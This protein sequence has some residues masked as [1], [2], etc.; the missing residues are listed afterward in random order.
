MNLRETDVGVNLP[1]LGAKPLKVLFPFIRTTW[2]LAKAA[3]EYSPA[4]LLKLLSPEFRTREALPDVVGKA[5]TGVTFLTAGAYL[6][7][8]GRL[9]GSAPRD[10]RE[11]E[12]FYEGEGKIQYA[13]RVGDRW[14][15]L[16]SLGPVGI[17]LAV[18]AS[19]GDSAEEGVRVDEL[20]V[21][22]GQDAGRWTANQTWLRQFQSLME[23]ISPS[24]PT[25]TVTK[26]IG[27]ILGSAASQQIPMVGGLRTIERITDPYLRAQKSAA[28]SFAA[29]IPGVPLITQ[30]WKIGEPRLD[31][32]GRP[33]KPGSGKGLKSLTPL[34][35]SPVAREPLNVK[36]TKAGVWPSAAGRTLTVSGKKYKLSDQEWE[37]YQKMVGAAQADALL[38]AGKGTEKKEMATARRSALK[39]FKV[40][41][42]GD[43][44]G[45]VRLP[46]RRRR[47]PYGG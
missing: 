9:T 39:E 13:V 34:G 3:W 5:L 27:R 24:E 10:P 23:A 4:N 37:V 7:A 20:L 47:N 45:R 44:S 42:L 22:A 2:N 14:V 11:A 16:L 35:L 28:E 18:A 19:I 15:S 36:A 12:R 40:E 17:N 32:F 38:A 30:R 41:Q 21:K 29:S 25:T 43:T 1:I 33:I 31:A 46:T 8:T 6:R 26:R